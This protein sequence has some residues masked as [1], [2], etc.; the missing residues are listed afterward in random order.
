M[1]KLVSSIGIMDQLS[2]EMVAKYREKQQKQK[3]EKEKQLNNINNNTTNTND[4]NSSIPSQ[5]LSTTMDRSFLSCIVSSIDKSTG[6][7]FADEVIRDN[8]NAFLIGGYETTAN[9]L[10][11]TS[12]LLAQNIDVEMKLQ[13]EIDR[14]TPTDRQLTYEDLPSFTYLNAIISESL[15]L[16]PVGQVIRESRCDTELGGKFIP[17]GTTV[18]AAA[19]IVHRD[20]SIWESPEEFKPERFLDQ[21]YENQQRIKQHYFP[22]GIGHRVCIGMKFA[23]EELKLACNKEKKKTISRTNKQTNQTTT[24]TLK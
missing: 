14:L 24:I 11:F 23:L 5:P 4:D 3:I 19:H 17:A 15:R 13:E 21:S 9:S 8:C 12:F 7:P 20:P 2:T 18:V 22:F 16:Y 6:L 1:K 10:G